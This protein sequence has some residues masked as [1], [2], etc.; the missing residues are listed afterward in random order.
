VLKL[1][2]L[3]ILNEVFLGFLGVKLKALLALELYLGG[4]DDDKIR[5]EVSANPKHQLKP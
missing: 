2:Y 3:L 1:I 5:G 4:D